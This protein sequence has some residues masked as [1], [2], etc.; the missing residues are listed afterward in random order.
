MPIPWLFP[1][2]PARLSVTDVLHVQK[3][4]LVIL[5]FFAKQVTEG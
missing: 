2:H 5:R 4:G 3:G 1:K